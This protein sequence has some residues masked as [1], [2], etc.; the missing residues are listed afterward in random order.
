MT[1]PMIK[2]T[3]YNSIKIVSVKQEHYSFVKSFLFLAF[4]ELVNAGKV[5][6]IVTIV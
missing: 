2:T 5:F 3:P 4:Q 1:C 6:A